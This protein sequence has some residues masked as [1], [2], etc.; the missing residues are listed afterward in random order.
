MKNL[1]LASTP[2]S[3]KTNDLITILRHTLIG[4]NR[5]CAH[6]GTI[7]GSSFEKCESVLRTNEEIADIRMFGK[8]VK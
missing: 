5:P 7:L 6:Y 8:Y 3:H 1:L 2:A 4:L